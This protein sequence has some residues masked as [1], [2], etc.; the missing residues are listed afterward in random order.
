MD[1]SQNSFYALTLFRHHRSWSWAAPGAKLELSGKRTV[2][3]H[4]AGCNTFPV[5][6][7]TLAA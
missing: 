3:S 1:L 4:F 2:L 5:I 6:C 7:A